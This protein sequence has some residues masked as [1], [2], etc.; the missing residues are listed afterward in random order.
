MKGVAGLEGVLVG[1]KVIRGA[2]FQKQPW[3]WRITQLW[4]DFLTSRRVI[5]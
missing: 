3:R 4:R 5:R 2:E 1:T